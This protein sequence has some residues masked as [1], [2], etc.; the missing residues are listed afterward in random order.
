MHAIV[1]FKRAEV[2]LF[3][4]ERGL[5]TCPH[6]LKRIKDVC[7]HSSAEKRVKTSEVKKYCI[8]K[9]MT[10]EKAMV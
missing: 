7:S 1:N 9:L 6:F 8:A 5:A 4:R 10:K 2:L 3:F